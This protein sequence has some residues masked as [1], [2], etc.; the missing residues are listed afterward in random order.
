MADAHLEAFHFAA[1]ALRS[2]SLQ[3]A[4]REVAHEALAYSGCGAAQGPL[5]HAGTGE[6]ADYDRRE[7]RGRIV[8]V[9]RNVT[10]HRSSQ[11]REAIAR[12]ALALVYVS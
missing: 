6:P 1:F 12:G 8:L 9:E 5:V 2:S 11:Y 3:V 10:F 4:G 7:V